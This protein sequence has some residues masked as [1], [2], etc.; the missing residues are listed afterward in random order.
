M[1]QEQLTR[2]EIDL[3]D[4]EQ[5]YL[6]RT[7]HDEASRLTD[8]RP[9]NDDVSCKTDVLHPYLDKIFEVSDKYL[10]RVFN[11]KLLH[12]FRTNCFRDIRG[13]RDSTIEQFVKAYYDF[14]K[15]EYQKEYTG[16]DSDLNQSIFSEPHAPK[17]LW[18]NC[19][20]FLRRMDSESVHLMVTSPPYYNARNYSQWKTLDDYL[21]EMSSIIKECYRVLDNH[22]PF[23][24]NVGDI[25]DN[26]NTHTKSSWGKR[27]IP[28][29]A[30]FTM[31]FEEHGFQFV[32]D[33]IWDKGEVQTQRH[34]NGNRPYPLYQYPI[35][36]YEHIFVFYKHRLDETLYP[37]P[38][39]GC[40]K[41][42][43]NA[44]SGVG[45]KSWEC[46]NLDCFERSAGNRG[47]RFSARTQLMTGLQRTENVVGEDLLQR[48]R[49]D[50]VKL[51]PVIK[52]NS[53]GEN[54]LGHTAPFPK[55]IPE[56][57]VQV[58]TGV[59]ESV[60]D[61]FAGAFTT[62]I[63]SFRQGRNSIGIELN[64]TMFRDAVLTRFSNMLGM[65][66]K[67]VEREWI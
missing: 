57:A 40:L 34:K 12:E 8:V 67:E 65:R 42:N 35:N 55:E 2:K 53:K 15:R 32:D 38:V 47:K 43:G 60:L 29:G 54:V 64:R 56:Y 63:E 28:L 33:F 19:L 50:V 3:N 16:A 25:F 41:V 14:V 17:A 6:W 24:F 21:D 22:R 20:D 7:T 31:I 30:Y 58:F 1:K 66:P 9:Q 52:I 36:C 48:W 51:A 39:C 37:C 59:N 27:R 62:T 61:P 45:V 13:D 46:K 44:Y 4:P 23:V 10:S 49:R 5:Y 11:E 18:G 26:D